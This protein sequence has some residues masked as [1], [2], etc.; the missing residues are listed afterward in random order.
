M[1][2][3]ISTSVPSRENIRWR[4]CIPVRREIPHNLPPANTEVAASALLNARATNTVTTAVISK[5]AEDIGCRGQAGSGKEDVDDLHVEGLKL[6][7]F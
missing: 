7:V 4:T 3:A 1:S 6:V 2:A 5:R